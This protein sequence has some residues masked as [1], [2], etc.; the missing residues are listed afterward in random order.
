MKE[1]GVISSHKFEGVITSIEFNKEGLAVSNNKNINFIDF[2]GET[3]WVSK[4]PFKPYKIKTNDNLLGILMGNGFIVIDSNTGEQLHEGRST[5]GGF[6]NIINRPGGGWVLSDRHE[7]LHL[8]NQQGFGIKRLFSGKIRNLIGWIDR[9]HLIIHDGDG[10]LRCIRLMA[11]STQRQ[12]EEKI[13]SWASKLENGELLV[14]SLEGEIWAGKPNTA[15]WD[16]L[17]LFNE[18]CLEPLNSI[19][20][21]DGWW[22]MNMENNVFNSTSKQEFEGFGHLIAS[23]SDNIFAVADNNG[24]LRIIG[25]YELIEQKNEKI[26]FEFEKIKYSLNSEKRRALFKMAKNAESIHDYEKAKQIYDTLEIENG[27]EK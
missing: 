5:Q 23:N 19:W 12:I 11:E 27:T 17:K 6:S 22:I 16:D 24:L 13:W 15:G 14:Q 25:S 7:Q 2:Q 26:S 3:R 8:F 9:D 10:C 18:K 1:W 21:K 20:T 4:M